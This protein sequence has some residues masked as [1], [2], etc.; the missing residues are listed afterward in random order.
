MLLHIGTSTFRVHTYILTPNK[1]K[2][3]AYKKSGDLWLLVLWSSI[4]VTFV[5]KKYLLFRELI[6]PPFMLQFFFD[7][8][9][10][11][12]YSCE[13]EH[14]YMS[15]RQFLTVSFAIAYYFKIIFLFKYL[16]YTLIQI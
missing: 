4:F 10:D 15:R 9:Y 6:A 14:G 13:G 8:A 11:I 1:K 2:V 16:L 12:R 3:P 7:R 5:V